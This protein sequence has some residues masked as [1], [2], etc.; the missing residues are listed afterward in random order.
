M[1]DWMAFSSALGVNEKAARSSVLRL[2][3]AADVASAL[4]RE[5][6]LPAEQQE[7]FI[8]IWEKR[9]ASLRHGL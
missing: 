7:A 6:F 4:C 3:G 5:S 1:K 9:A 8:G 2:A